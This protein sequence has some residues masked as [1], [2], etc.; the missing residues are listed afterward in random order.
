MSV[1]KD[2]RTLAARTVT[3]V[4][5][6]LNGETVEINDTR[7]YDNGKKVVPAYLCSPVFADIYNYK[8][9]LI[10]SGYYR[11]SDLY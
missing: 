5:Q 2:T 7:T 10:D 4:K 1:F 11:E 3:M 9:I 6:I 8:T